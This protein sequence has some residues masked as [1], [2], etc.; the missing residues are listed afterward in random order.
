[1]PRPAIQLAGFSSLA[2]RGAV[3]ALVLAYAV[4]V[5]GSG[6]DRL[7]ETRPVA[8]QPMVSRLVPALFRNAAHRADAARAMAQGKPDI[9]RAAALA[10]LDHDPLHRQPAALLGAAL[11]AQNDFTAAEQAF[12]V[13]ANMGWRDPMTQAYWYDAAIRQ[14]D[15][16]RAAQRVDAIL[17]A[18]PRVPA[19]DDLVQP[20]TQTATGRAALAQQMAADPA[21]LDG[22]LNAP[23]RLDDEI[24]TARS[25]MIAAAG[26][27]GLKLGCERPTHF[28]ADLLRRGLR[29]EAQAIWQ[30]HCPHRV[31]SGGLLNGRFDNAASE[32]GAAPFGWQRRGSGDVDMRFVPAK[33]GGQAAKIS[34]S[35]AIS[36]VFL[37]QAISLEPGR[38]LLRADV[39]AQN[40]PVSGQVAASAA[41]GGA[42]ITPLP[43]EGDIAAGGQ[44]L[45]IGA[46]GLQT[47]GLW[48]RP[49][50][51][52]TIQNVRL[53]GGPSQRR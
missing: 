7:A 32:S 1:M 21:W 27:A 28:T 50:A 44:W 45:N 35:G 48:V 49:G 40:G 36:R 34:N 3:V 2:A 13:A 25:G 42:V 31:A 37:T 9:A 12:R 47:L 14:R 29:A 41:C 8:S 20:M 11:L 19:L 23:V 51:A 22:Y 15:Y 24:M 39:T 33:G 52:V 46:C 30:A 10:A 6:F 4:S 26:A 16:G 38:Y 53:D 17:R 18:N 5:W 43:A